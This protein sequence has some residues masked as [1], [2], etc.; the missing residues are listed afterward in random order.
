MESDHG[1][2]DEATN[3]SG[4]GGGRTNEFKTITLAE[5]GANDRIGDTRTTISNATSGS[6]MGSEEGEYSR[7]GEAHRNGEDGRGGDFSKDASISGISNENEGTK[8][9]DA[10]DTSIRTRIWTVSIT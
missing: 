1:T 9:S 7:T 10:E 5:E 2:D 8:S 6:R 4:E 3:T